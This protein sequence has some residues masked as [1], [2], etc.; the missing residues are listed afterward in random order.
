MAGRADAM[1]WS[2]FGAIPTP[3]PYSECYSA[4][5]AGVI[6]G[7]ENEP[8]SILANK[9]YE[10]CK[11]FAMTDHLVLPMGLFISGKVLDKLPAEYRDIIIEEARNAAIRE[12][13]DIKIKNQEA[14]EK[15]VSSFGV[16][17]TNPDKQK[18][19]EKGVP[20]QDEFAKQ[21]GL[22][23]LLTELRKAMR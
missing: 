16:K 17:V 21:F 10:P 18:L 14:I 1:T 8:V 4:L 19:M 7:G 9:F 6:D 2:S 15:M 20:V 11:Y 23:E 22:T 5:E 13:D 3:M 12:R